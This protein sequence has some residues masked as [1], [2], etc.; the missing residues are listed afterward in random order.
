M[1]SMGYGLKTRNLIRYRAEKPVAQSGMPVRRHD[2]K[3]DFFL[4]RDGGNLLDHRS[5]HNAFACLRALLQTR[6]A[7]L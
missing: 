2:H 6:G 1:D 7:E 5:Q 4:F 3:I